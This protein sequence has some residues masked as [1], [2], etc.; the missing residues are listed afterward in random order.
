MTFFVDANVF[1][2]A[3][4]PSDYRAPCL[5]VIEAIARGD[6]DGQTSIVAL[7]EVW[8][9]EHTGRT[10]GLAGLTERT[11]ALMSPLL[12]VDDET[13]RA[14]LTFEAG[15]IG[16]ADRLHVATCLAHGIDTIVTA[17]R[18][19]D[20]VRDLRR[21]DPLDAP[22]LRRL[23]GAGRPRGSAARRSPGEAG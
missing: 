8:H 15:S 18:G 6:A 22:A 19:F 17:D 5:V 2:Y 16:T 10:P 23:L 20:A 9:L 1:L 4:A 11:Y 3:A 14:A 12:P 7:E 21:V 13:F